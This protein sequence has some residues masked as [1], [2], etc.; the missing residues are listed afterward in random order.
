MRAALLQPTSLPRLRYTDVRR[1]GVPRG[2][3]PTSLEPGANSTRALLGNERGRGSVGVS[4]HHY[5]HN[6]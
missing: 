2:A 5:G 6:A 4:Y 3:L 1:A